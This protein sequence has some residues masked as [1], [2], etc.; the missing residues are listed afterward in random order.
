MGTS[1]Y[2]E[3]VS[4]ELL[5]QISELKCVAIRGLRKLFKNPAGGDDRVAVDHLDLDLFQ[6]QVTVLLGHNG[7]G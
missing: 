1:H 4:T 5:Q 3:A 2:I 7:A 6:N